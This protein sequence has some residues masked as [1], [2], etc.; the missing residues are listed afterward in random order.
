M[1]IEVKCE[2]SYKTTQAEGQRKIL[3]TKQSNVSKLYIYLKHFREKEDKRKIKL[4]VTLAK[5]KI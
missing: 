5:I 2:F 3:N 4:N 1:K